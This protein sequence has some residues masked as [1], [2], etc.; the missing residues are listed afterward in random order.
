M[1]KKKVSALLSE[2]DIH[3]R[4]KVKVVIDLSNCAT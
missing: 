2:P 1:K 3:I 4:E